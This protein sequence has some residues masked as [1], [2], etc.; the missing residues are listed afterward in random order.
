MTIP[1]ERILGTPAYP[2][3]TKM[4]NSLLKETQDEEEKS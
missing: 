1:E 4:F 3:H 2:K